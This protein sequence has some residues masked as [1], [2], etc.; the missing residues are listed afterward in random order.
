M[1]LTVGGAQV[2]DVGPADVVQVLRGDV[3]LEDVLEVR[4]QPEMDVEEVRHVGDVVDDV[5]AVGA[6]DEDAVPPPVGP[7]V[8]G[9]L[10]NLGDPDR[11]V[12]RIALVVVPDEQQAAAHVGR[13][14]PGARRLG[15]ALGVGHQ[16]AAAVAAPAPVVERAGDL[17][18]LDGALRQ[19]AAHVPAV[20]VQDLDVAVRVGENHQL[21]AERLNRVRFAVQEFLRDAQAVPAP[22]VP[23]RQGAGI[24]LTDADRVGVGTQAVTSNF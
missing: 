21:G 8:A 9:G 12:R 3:A 19:V 1:R 4:R 23:C 17:V 5:A 7:F 18:A 20:A 15:R 16:L 22:G 6:L 14:R 13:P 11:G 24:D 2:V 10:G